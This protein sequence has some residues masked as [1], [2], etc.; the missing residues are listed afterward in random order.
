MMNRLMLGMMLTSAVSMLGCQI[1]TGY[2]PKRDRD[3]LEDRTAE[4]QLMVAS[5]LERQ[6]VAGAKRDG[7]VYDFH[8]ESGGATL[9]DLG[10]RRLAIL[11]DQPGGG[12]VVV[13]LQMGD[14]SEELHQARKSAVREYVESL[15]GPMDK[16][17][18]VDQHPGGDGIG[19][20]AILETIESNKTG[21][22]ESG[23][24]SNKPSMSGG[25][26]SNR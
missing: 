3:F 24:T 18:I 19:S 4:N 1:F 21:G 7:S 2:N 11:T 15:G 12:A 25:Q 10:R 8:F 6:I 20:E 22:E 26:S 16:F 17:E 14:A 5:I 23:S 9:T 13:R